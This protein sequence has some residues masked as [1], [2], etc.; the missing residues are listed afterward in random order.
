MASSAVTARCTATTSVTLSGRA[1]AAGARVR[2]D[3]GERV[4]VEQQTGA[5]FR[6]PF[7]VK[8]MPPEVGEE[9]AFAPASRADAVTIGEHVL[10]VMAGIRL[11]CGQ[12]DQMR[13]I[14]GA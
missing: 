9:L 5:G 3:L 10:H 4:A 7:R 11:V 14:D 12:P 1:P 2:R 8:V 6:R 13:E